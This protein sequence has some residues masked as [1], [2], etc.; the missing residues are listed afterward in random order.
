MIVYKVH[1][2]N[3]HEILYFFKFFWLMASCRLGSPTKIL[4]QY[5]YLLHILSRLIFYT[6]CLLEKTKIILIPIYYTNYMFSIYHN[7]LFAIM[8]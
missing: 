6:F 1:I 5:L 7:Y 2:S 4:L 3:I 8:L